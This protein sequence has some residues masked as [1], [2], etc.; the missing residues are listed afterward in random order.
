VLQTF[1]DSCFNAGPSGCA[2]YSSSPKAISQSL[3]KLYDITKTHPFPVFS[4]NTS[5]YGVVDYNFL[6]DVIFDS[7]YTPYA[8]FPPLANALAELS[9]GNAEPIWNMGSSSVP[10]S[11]NEAS[12]AI[13]CNDGNQIPG[14]L[15]DAERY[16]NE[17]AKASD[18]ANV[19]A[20][21]R[22][23]CS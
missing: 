10:G 3:T 21:E 22:I 19:W 6:R 17:L 13:A 18:W 16:Y 2:F 11:I 20:K 15:E 12:L 23:S 7:L 9:K 8:S 1:F 5:S 14:T 4:R